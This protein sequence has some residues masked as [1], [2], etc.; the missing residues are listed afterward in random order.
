MSEQLTNQRGVDSH[1]FRKS[2]KMRMRISNTRSILDEIRHTLIR[3]P[4][5]KHYSAQLPKFVLPGPLRVE[6]LNGLC[7]YR[8]GPKSSH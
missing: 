2:I 6:Y 8:I 4:L 3:N 1:T 7:N 5:E